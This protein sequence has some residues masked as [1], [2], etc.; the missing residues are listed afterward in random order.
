[1]ARKKRTDGG[2]T[3][4]IEDK[5]IPKPPKDMRA[6][7][8]DMLRTGVHADG[9]RVTKTKVTKHYKVQVEMTIKR[10]I[11]VEVNSDSPRS[12]RKAVLSSGLASLEG[13]RDLQEAD[14]GDM[15]MGAQY[16][17]IGVEEGALS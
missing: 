16:K 10:V 17:V 4:I 14:P 5:Y 9:T 12:A 6:G 15:S 1:M 8:R 13:A 11:E 3:P 2:C 7:V